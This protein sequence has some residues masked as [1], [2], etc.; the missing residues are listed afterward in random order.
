MS[1]PR[2][3]RRH[4]FAQFLICASGCCCGR[5]DKGKPAVPVPWLK[6]EWRARRLNPRVQLT[7]TE[8]L[9]PCDLVNVVAVHS[10][11]EPIWLGGLVDDSAFELLLQWATDSREA[12]S[13]LP[14][15]L[16]LA[17]YRFE[18]FVP[19]PPTAAVPLP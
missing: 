7:V 16:A 5:V 8:C 18:R 3:T 15:P 11:H 17:P 12:G 1:F 6:A 14:L 2:A 9:G 10:E 13:L 4:S 19:P